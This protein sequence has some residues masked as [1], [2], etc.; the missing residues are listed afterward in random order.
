[1]RSR[2]FA[3][4]AALAVLAVL[5]AGGGAPLGAQSVPTPAQ[6]DSVFAGIGG[7]EAPG[8]AVGVSVDGR[9]VLERA[10][11]MADLEHG[12]VNTPASRFEAGSVSKQ[13]TAAA[14]ILLALEGKLSLD[15]DVR[16]HFP[17]LPDYGETVTVRHLL[18]HTSG[19]RDWGSVAS[20]GGW[21]R[22]TRVHTHEHVLDI[23][24]RQRSL[25]YPPGR[26][27]SYTNSGYNL[28]AMLVERVSGMPFAEFSRERIF[29]PLGL[30]RTEWRDDFTRVVEDRA[31]AYEPAPGGGWRMDMPFEDVHGNGGLLTTVG[32]LLAWTESLETGALAGPALVEEM[33]RQGVLTDGR[34]IDYASGLVVSDYRDLPLV[35]HSG[36]TA[37]YRAY[38]ARFPE[39][40]VGVAV[41]CNAADAGA[42][43]LLHGVADL[44]LAGALGPEA[45]EPEGVALPAS[46]L[47]AREGTYRNTRT[48]EA[49]RLSAADGGLRIDD[50]TRLVPLSD[51]RFQTGGG[52][53]Y[54]FEAASDASERS[55]FVREDGEGDRVRFEPVASFDPTT[56]ELAAYTGTFHSDEAEATYTF[57]VQDGRLHVEARYGE[58]VPLT[59]VYRDAFEGRGG[60]W[61][62][63]RDGAGRVVEVSSITSRVWDM[64][65]G[66]VR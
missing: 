15:D 61:R 28:Q 54:T 47:A 5:A 33:H 6:V 26:H 59:P 20:L 38:L 8:C 36:S 56:A 57:S 31:V 22:T 27:Y 9:P 50:R 51:R 16:T 23:L 46:A 7:S 19:L 4:R 35:R 25:N 18:N 2:R 42:G 11:G 41:L 3:P 45:G 29:E 12:V 44:A 53:T 37:G 10:Y 13:F 52:T 63:L 64:R 32:D 21:P 65:F 60:T 1:M 40:R 24:S 55:A 30:T 62:F 49:L 17:E 43:G 14:V 66:R 34:T 48:H 58:S 39:E